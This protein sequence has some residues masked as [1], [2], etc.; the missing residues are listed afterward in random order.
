M[1]KIFKYLNK[2]EWI[3][4]GICL[5]FIVAQVWL[6]LK[7]PDFMAEITR[8]VETPGSQ[9]S[10][11][12]IQGAWMLLCALGSLT[13]AIVIVFFSAKIGSS[14]AQHLRSKIYDKIDT[15]SAGEINKF[16]TASLLT[17]STN[18]ITQIQQ[19]IT[20]GLQ[21][22]V[23]A[24]ILVVW[25]LVKI[26]GKGFEWSVA[27][28]IA[29]LIVVIM[30]ASLLIFVIPKFKKMQR[31]TDNINRITRENLTGLAVVRAYNAEYYQ[32][33]KFERANDE[34]TKTQ[35]FTSKGMSILTPFMSF[36][37]NGLTLAIYIIGAVLING[38]INGQ[39]TIFSNM[40]IF[41]SYAMQVVMA[42]MIIA[43]M[44]NILPRA[45]V[46]A[47]RINE[48]LD[49]ELSIK[50]GTRTE[51][52]AGHTGEIEFR[53]VSFKYPEA[54]D[55]VLKGIN[56][57]VQSGETV[58]FI[59]S[60]GS[61]K[62]TLIN[63]ILRFFDATTGEILIDGVNVK[64]YT[65]EALH[66]KIGYVPQKAVMFSGTVASNVALGEQEETE[67]STEEDIRS[68][69]KIAQGKDFVENMKGGYSA[70]IAR[71]GS[72]V[73]GGQKQRLAIARAICKKP[74][75]YIFDDSFSALD[76]KTDRN[77]RTALKKETSGTTNIIVAQRIGTIKDA[78]KIIVID[79][80]RLAGMG[81]HKELLKNC[82][83]YKEIAMSQLSEE[84]L[85]S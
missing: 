43:G 82:A 32:E 28:G 2:K 59:G 47:N 8:L 65:L 39:L 12:W 3:M 15:F 60:T 49:T 24:P 84:E 54:A 63:L 31:L 20:I 9:M 78:D 4:T 79:E 50:D 48:V 23:K 53:N 66:E 80:G 21:M 13:S 29:S 69:V 46:S 14:F 27:T 37:M 45:Q 1:L 41:S 67:E 52:E 73:S 44:F 42:F 74:E 51:G 68:A 25:A 64:E 6:D 40:V 35:L 70:E 19:I 17:R 61:G 71:G 33:A 62:S 76:Y 83:V 57:S 30:V 75:I 77:L 26:S 81:T 16:S 18:D 5:A 72:N 58:S 7:L 36:I 85:A 38:A 55:Y 22:I 34:L 11:I 10:D 56:F